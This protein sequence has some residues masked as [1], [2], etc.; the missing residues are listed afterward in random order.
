MFIPMWIM[1]I[2]FG[3]AAGYIVTGLIHGL[4]AFIGS[5]PADRP[6]LIEM[7]SII[8]FWPIYHLAH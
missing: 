3:L 6:D 2:V 5:P 1:W 4:T 7:M 8:F